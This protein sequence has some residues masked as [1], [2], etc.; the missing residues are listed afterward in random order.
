MSAAR[1]TTN[2]TSRDKGSGADRRTGGPIL[3]SG[4][5]TLYNGAPNN[6]PGSKAIS[7]LESPGSSVGR[8]L[9]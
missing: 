3:D 1:R 8:A 6:K 4:K 9:H 5:L 7:V 2:G